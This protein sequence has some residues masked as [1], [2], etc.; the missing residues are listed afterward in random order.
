MFIVTDYA[1]VL[2]SQVSVFPLSEFFCRTLEQFKKLWRNIKI[3]LERVAG[4]WLT[5]QSLSASLL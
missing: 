1:H 2:L 3:I 4:C 5:F